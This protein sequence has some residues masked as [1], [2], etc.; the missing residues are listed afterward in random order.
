MS[1]ST[2]DLLPS[3]SV[4]PASEHKATVIWLHGLG[5]DGHDFEPIV[6]ELKL[7]AELGVKFLFP[8]A[9]VMPVTINGGYEMRAWYDIRD[10]D[11]ANREDKEGVRNSAKL[12]EQLIEAEIDSGIPSDKIILAGFSQGGAIALHL[13]TRL[14][15]KLAGIV[16]LST[17]LTMPEQLETEKSSINKDTPVFMAH[18]SQDPVVPMQRGQYS[19]KM[20]EDNGFTVSWQDY[21]MAHAVCLEEIQALGQFLEKQFA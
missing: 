8:H 5:A 17:Y 3:V 21:P 15:K 11:L 10:A 13:A 16:A 9:P 20:L 6:P 1:E 14:E 18:G 2:S 19:A 12:V 4:N 7:S